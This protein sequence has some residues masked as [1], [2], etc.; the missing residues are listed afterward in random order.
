MAVARQAL[1][2]LTTGISSILEHRVPPLAPNGLRLGT[3]P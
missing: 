3:L 1:G 2:Q